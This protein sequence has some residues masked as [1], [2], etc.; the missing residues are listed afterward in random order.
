MRGDQCILLSFFSGIEAAASSFNRLVGAPILH[1]SWE[2]DASCQKIISKHF[3]S[4]KIRG[5]V[6]KEDPQ[7]IIDLIDRYDPHQTCVVIFMAAPPCPDFSVVND[8]AKGIQGEDGSKFLRYAQLASQIESGLGGR[9]VRH[10]VENVIFQ[11]RAEAQHVSNALAASPIVVDAADFGLVGR[12]RLWWSRIDWRLVT[13]NPITGKSL[14]WGK[15]Q[16]YPRLM[17]EAPF[18]E[19]ED[20][21]TSGHEFHPKVVQHIARLPCMTTPAPDENGRAPPKRSKTRTDHETRNRWLAG[22]RQY[23]PWNYQEH[24]MVKDPAG[25]LV[26]P[27][28]TIKEQLHHFPVNYTEHGEVTERERN[29]MLGNSWHMGVSL[30]LLLFLLQASQT[31][32][33]PVTIRSHRLDL[34]CGIARTCGVYPGPGRPPLHNIDMPF[35]TTMQDHWSAAQ[36]VAFPGLRPQP[37]SPLTGHTCE[38]LVNHLGDVA[39]LRSEVMQEIQEMVELW[40]EHTSAWWTDLPSHLQKVYWHHD[41]EMVTQIPVLIS[42]LERCQYP[43]LAELAEDLNHGFA[44]VG[45]LHAGVGW[46]PRLDG[47]YQHPFSIETFQI[48]NQSYVHQRLRQASVDEHWEPMLQELLDDRS[49][50]RLEGPFRAPPDWPI[51]TIGIPGEQL[52]A[53]PEGPVFAAFCFSVL[54]S[55][56]IRRCEDHRRSHHNSTIAV[57]DVPHHDNIDAYVRLAMWWLD[58]CPDPVQVW[59]HDLDSAYRQLGL[60]DQ[61]FAY[62]IINTPAGAMLFR[63]TALCF[64][65]TASVWSF[66]RFADSLVSLTH[67]LFLTPVLHYVDDFGGIETANTA[68]SAFDTFAAFF[69]CLGLKTKDKKAEAPNSAQKLL[70]V[71]IEIEPEGVRLSPCPVRVTKIKDTITKALQ[72]NQLSPEMAHKLCGKLIFLQSTSFGQ[73]GKAPLR[74][75]YS[76]ACQGASEFNRLTTALEASLRTL[77]TMLQHLHPRWFPRD[78]TPPHD[79]LWTDAYYAP[80]DLTEKPFKQ[81]GHHQSGVNA[82][83]GWGFVIACGDRHFFSHGSVPPWVIRPFGSRRAFI[84]LLEAIAPVIACVLMRDFLSQ[85]LLAFVDNQASLQALR[86]GYGR[87]FAINGLLCFFW[88]FATRLGLHLAMEWVPSHLNIADPVSRHDCKGACEAGWQEVDQPLDQLYHILVKCSADLSYAAEQAVDDC[89]LLQPAFRQQHLVLGGGTGTEMVKESPCGFWLQ[90]SYCAP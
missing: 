40:Q 85:H 47:R 51:E 9:E 72:D 29:R 82:E 50:G 68:Q 43:N 20:L 32:S 42:L 4:A 63:H 80:G 45:A 66:N 75:L 78:G 15:H 13:T 55:D 23:A 35:C 53:A 44:T 38:I 28:I 18:D 24:A 30:F 49:K 34:V 61:T 41:T 8:S 70:G 1:I 87:D 6:L 86:K 11:Q 76:R 12:P 83:N 48:A 71:I 84:Y 17:I 57:S 2:I 60:R 62:V 79:T 52:L 77:Q 21:V 26:I 22:H 10:L 31:Q 14:K 58:K 37:V 73:T 74:C 33:V 89:L 39:R 36:Q 16:Q 7:T 69:R 54:Q 64:G 81:R 5:D 56:K 90:Q 59:A 88:S 19:V 65:S 3:P 46:W 25:N 67:H 27:D